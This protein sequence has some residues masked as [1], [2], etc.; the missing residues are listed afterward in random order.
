MKR[1]LKAQKEIDLMNYLKE[2]TDYSNKKIKSMIEH[3]QI[4][5]NGKRPKLPYFLLVDD[6]ISI[7][8]DKIYKTPF[9]ILYEDEKFLV[10]NKKSGLLTVGTDKEKEETLYHQVYEYLHL[11]REKVFV[12]HRLDKETSGIVVFAKREE[13]KNILQDNW[14]DIILSR[15]Y[16][17]LVHGIVKKDGKIESYLKEE[18]NT[19]VHSSKVGK[20]AVTHYHPVKERNNIT[21]LDISIKTGRKNQIRVHMKE[22]EMPILGDK[23][24]GIK[25]SSS[26]LMLHAYELSFIYPKEKKKYQFQTPIPNDF[27]KIV[28]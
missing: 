24:Y 16:V 17:A 14:N 23:K 12:V 2:N 26:R 18:K 15:K 3:N 8:T 5:V 4:K 28:S 1:V 9:A 13:V 27:L 21:L 19:F 22:K 7:T 25:D 6:E 11:K 20:L 10:V